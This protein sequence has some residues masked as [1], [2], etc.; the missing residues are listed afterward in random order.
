MLQPGVRKV[1]LKDHRPLSPER[2]KPSERNGANRPFLLMR[3]RKVQESAAGSMFV[4]PKGA[5]HRQ[6]AQCLAARHPCVANPVRVRCVLVNIRRLL[7]FSQAPRVC[8]KRCSSLSS[9]SEACREEPKAVGQHMRTPCYVSFMSSV[10]YLPARRR[11]RRKRRRSNAVGCGSHAVSAARGHGQTARA[12][13][14]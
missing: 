1:S 7:R 11:P 5:V 10:R 14:S 8:L 4:Q 9:L 13:K 2:R 6:K 12:Y 3:Q